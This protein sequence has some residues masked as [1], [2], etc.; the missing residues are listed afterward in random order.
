MGAVL[1]TTSIDGGEYYQCNSAITIWDTG[2]SEATSL[3][4]IAIP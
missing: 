3:S 2:C 4:S 1:S